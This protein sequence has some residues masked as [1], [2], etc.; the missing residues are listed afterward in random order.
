MEEDDF[1]LALCL[2]LFLSLAFLIGLGGVFGIANSKPT[3][4]SGFWVGAELTEEVVRVSVLDSEMSVDPTTTMDSASES[5][6]V[7]ETGALAGACREREMSVGDLPF[8]AVQFPPKLINGQMGQLQQPLV[9]WTPRD[10]WKVENQGQAP[11]LS[12]NMFT[13]ILS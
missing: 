3:L 6:G 7:V 9:S 10:Q 11:L 12:F 4:G 2:D 13:Q 5:A 1:D 8:V